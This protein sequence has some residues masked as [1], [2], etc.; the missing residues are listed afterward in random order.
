MEN[1]I[2]PRPNGQHSL[3]ESLQQEVERVIDRFR[4]NPRI[5]D[6]LGPISGPSAATLWQMGPAIDLSETDDSIALT[7]EMPG[8][9]R[10]DLEVT[11]KGN[12]LKLHGH[13]RDD[14]DVENKTYH[15]VERSYGEFERVIPLGFVPE[16][17]AVT[18]V[19][20]DGLLRV[21]VRK[22]PATKAAAHKVPIEQA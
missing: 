7:A 21:S 11:V 20:Q 15:L 9:S 16:D 17:D 19:L 14:R 22:S 18:A 12:L 4:F 8:M 1:Q 13:K 6:I 5:G 10:D 2:L 3:W